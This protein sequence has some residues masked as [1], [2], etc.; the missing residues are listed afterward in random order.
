MLLSELKPG[1]GAQLIV[2]IG[3]QTLEFYTT[4]TEVFDNCIYVEPITQDDKVIGFSAKGLILDFIITDSESERAFQFSNVKIR[5]I[6]NPKDDKIYHE[7]NAA[8]EGKPINR[9][10]AC[11]V[12]LGEEGYANV[13]LGSPS[14][15][16]T[17][18]DI[19]VSGIAFIC[20][21]DKD[22]PDG[23]IVHVNFVDDPTGTTFSLAAIIVRSM[24]MERSRIMYGC[25]LNQESNSIAKFVNDKQR[26][27]LKSAR[28][29]NLAAFVEENNKK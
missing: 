25:K 15:P 1:T 19:S 12:W 26:E 6:K 9:R 24:E 14:F 28:Q 27:K 2:R 29:S 11:R 20:D 13:G 5:T 4:V 10:G 17:V 7:V 3:T 21:R 8:G 23:S 16:I 22:I 18:K